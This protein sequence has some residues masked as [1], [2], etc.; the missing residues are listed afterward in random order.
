MAQNQSGDTLGPAVGHGL[1][2]DPVAAKQQQGHKRYRLNVIQIPAL[3]IFG[4]FL[5][6]SLVVLH[7]YL[8]GILA[9]P[10]LLQYA[11]LLTIYALVSWLI[12]YRF[13]TECDILDLGF[14]FLTMD[15]VLFF[16]LAIYYSGGEKSLLFFLMVIR[17]ADQANTSFKRVIFFSHFSLLA[18]IILLLYLVGVE[19]RSLNGSIEILKCCAIYFINLDVHERS[20]S[21][22]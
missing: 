7:N 19:H 16:V 18:Y 14:F 12:L 4:V 1:I 2:L 3:R 8:L 5:L 21:R 10:P 17:V 13:Y 22:Q 11:T 20:P 9:W 6:L 15:I